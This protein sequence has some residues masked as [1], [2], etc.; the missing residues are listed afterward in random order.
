MNSWKGIIT[1]KLYCLN[2][3]GIYSRFE[4]DIYSKIHIFKE[5]PKTIL[6]TGYPFSYTHNA[7]DL[8]LDSIVYNW[9][10]PLEDIGFGGAYNPPANP[11]PVPF[12]APYTVNSPLPG[13]VVLDPQS[14]QISYNSNISGNFVSVIR[15]DAFKCGQIVAS[16]YREIQAVLI[17][18]PNL[19]SGGVNL[20]P[21]VTPPFA[22]PNQYYTTVLKF[23][24][25]NRKI[26]VF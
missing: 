14:G 15:V 6:C 24:Q 5:E 7:S 3:K 25:T 20:P 12:L 21:N 2:K 17:G 4:N 22:L 23:F 10:Q 11:P 9:D 8:E 1:W 19:A 26:V 18:C 13:G 16:I